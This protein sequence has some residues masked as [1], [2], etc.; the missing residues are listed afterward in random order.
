MPMRIPEPKAAEDGLRT[1]ERLVSQ[2]DLDFAKLAIGLY[3]PD[4]DAMMDDR[5]AE[6]MRA[7]RA[8]LRELENTGSVEEP[9]PGGPRMG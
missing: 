9:A 1:L 5:Q 3:G 8:G 7:V 4:F 2:G 6:R